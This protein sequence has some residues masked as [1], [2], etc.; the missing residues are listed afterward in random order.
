GRASGTLRRG[1]RL[2]AQLAE[3]SAGGKPRDSTAAW[4]PMRLAGKP[5]K[6]PSASPG[7]ARPKTPA[8]S[9]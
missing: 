7:A 8:Q 4:C 1:D 6:A 3:L 5:G 9:A 2:Q